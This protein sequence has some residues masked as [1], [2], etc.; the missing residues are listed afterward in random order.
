MHQERLRRCRGAHHHATML[1]VGDAM[2]HI[3]VATNAALLLRAATKPRYQAATR[4]A[5]RHATVRAL[6]A[7]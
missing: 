6:I 2:Q 1:A 7:R 3:A 5:T 4:H